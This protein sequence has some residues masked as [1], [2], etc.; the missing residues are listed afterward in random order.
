VAKAKKTFNQARKDIL[1]R[2][3]AGLAA[4]DK[5]AAGADL[6]DLDHLPLMEA[7]VVPPRERVYA[8]PVD[9]RPPMA[10]PVTFEVDVMA[11]THEA[12][13]RAAKRAGMT[14]D[15]FSDL[16]VR[17]MLDAAEA[18]A[19]ASRTTRAASSDDLQASI[20]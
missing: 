8:A 5:R 14:T 20:P 10:P 19:M 16:A 7:K 12:I 3:A 2:T 17:C 18:D 6:R 13:R 9:D 11:R 15:E 4:I 1:E